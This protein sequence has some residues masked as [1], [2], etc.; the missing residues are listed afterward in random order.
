MTPAVPAFWCCTSCLYVLVDLYSEGGGDFF[1]QACNID[2]L[3]YLEE[4]SELTVFQE[5]AN[6]KHD[7]MEDCVGWDDED[8]EF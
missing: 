5:E 1:W 4:I 2:S 7:E 8:G 6:D 3:S